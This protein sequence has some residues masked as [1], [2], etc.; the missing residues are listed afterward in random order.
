[1]TDLKRLIIITL[2]FSFILN[3][4][5]E[6]R[7]PDKEVL[8]VVYGN[9]LYKDDVVAMLPAGISP[10]D[11]VEIIKNKTELW[12]RKQ[13]LLNQANVNLTEKQKDVEQIVEDYRAS[14]LIDK[15]KQEFLKQK[16]DTNINTNEIREYYN[17]YSETFLLSK[18]IIKG[19][20]LKIPIDHDKYSQVKNIIYRKPD[21]ITEQIKK[22]AS[23][24]SFRFKDFSQEWT[25]FSE[26]ADQ[27][28]TK[29]LNSQKKLKNKENF[30]TKDEN[31][32]YFIKINDAK[33][34][35]E[36]MPFEKAENEIKTLLINKQKTELMNT[37]ER[38]VYQNALKNGDLK[39]HIN[40]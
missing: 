26:I 4:C 29:T 14:L 33:I 22:I 1:M 20:F 28:P 34:I 9:S 3:S 31:F 30:S 32:F 10:E 37:L 8:A 12:M 21:N 25:P 11:S 35:G 16:I 24:G 27:M 7:A 23:D 2:F 13:L 39:I 36:P 17:V 38:T 6:S 18:E 15:Y 40:D 19:F 5:T